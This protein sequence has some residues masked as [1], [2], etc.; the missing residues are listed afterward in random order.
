MKKPLQGK[1][2]FRSLGSYLLIVFIPLSIICAFYI[3]HFYKAFRN[4]ILTNVNKDLINISTRI[5]TELSIFQN[6][7][8]QIEASNQLGALSHEDDPVKIN[9]A[10]SMLSNFSATNAFISE[11]FLTIP[12][13]NNVL[14]S[15]TSNRISYFTERYYELEGLS[16]QQVKDFFTSATPKILPSLTLHQFMFPEEKIL[17]FS[18]PI[19]TDYLKQAGNV[20]FQVPLP[21]MEQLFNDKLGSYSA[22]SFLLDQKL[23]VITAVNASPDLYDWAS[24]PQNL[25]EA[26]SDQFH[27][28]ENRYFVCSFTSP[29]SGL[30]C[31][32]LIP[33][34]QDTF[35]QITQL[36]LLF[37][38]SI[39]AASAVSMIVIVYAMRFNYFPLRRLQDKAGQLT[40]L[41][42]TKD[43]LSDIEDALELLNGR[44]LHLQKRLESTATSVKSAR[45]QKLLADGYQ[46]TQDF[47]MDC[48][49]LNL[50]FSH[51]RLFVTTSIVHRDPCD[52]EA[53]LQEIKDF[54]SGSF[55][56]YYLRTIDGKKLIM[57]HS[58]PETT[59]PETITD[60]YGKMHACFMDQHALLITTGIGTMT[61][62]I[63]QMSQSYLNSCTALD[64]RFVKG[65]GQVI[66]FEEISLNP[67]AGYPLELFEKCRNA[68]R[69]N[70]SVRIQN[71]ITQI[72]DSVKTNNYPLA[73][74]RGIC[75]DL[76][77]LVTSY[78][79]DQS[80]SHSLLQQNLFIFSEIE[81]IQD[82]VSYLTKWQ[83]EL[84]FNDAALPSQKRRPAE[85]AEILSYL[86]ENCLSCE[87]SLSE[88]AE[89]FNMPLPKFSQ[90]FK[91]Q[92]QQDA[93]KYTIR[94][95]MDKAAQLLTNTSQNVDT[96]AQQTGYYNSSS[97]I[98]RFKQVY[99]I[100]PNEYRKIHRP[101]P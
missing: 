77:N 86:D 18:Y 23:G 75:F 13:M 85:I 24:D 93:L 46:S 36:N 55:E 87:F 66:H 50:H 100:T 83:Q 79:G 76:V 21:N 49:E 82:L 3:M 32:T 14:N 61:D 73:I 60:I 64:Y 52:T 98:R 97:F 95:R 20:V 34:N 70:H 38:I 67:N 9:S 29:E 57:V 16:P 11:I 96:I 94:V 89:H 56:T 47:N 2:F 25:S 40:N 26:F 99:G 12:E 59:A 91:E 48:Q 19:Y 41:E 1:Q 42:R 10:K 84:S 33:Q 37:F 51:S 65:N 35:S 71:C 68:L 63:T 45:L 78:R 28:L 58:V 74:A 44:S 53:I 30:S 22:V 72:I 39:L 43:E 101:G 62:D 7:A 31:L 27:S 54:L 8:H 17:L 90:F 92:M 81:T 5:D 4:E 80:G 88:T 6:T 69:T 15:S